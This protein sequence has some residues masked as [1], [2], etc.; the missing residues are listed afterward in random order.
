MW[1][2]LPFDILANIFS[3]LPPHSLACANAVCRHW[4]ACATAWPLQ[5][6]QH[7]PW[8]MALPARNCELGCLAHNPVCDSWV[9]LPLDFVPNPVRPVGSK[10]GLVLFR[11][12]SS[13]NFRLAIC[14]PFTQEYRQL[15]MLN[16]ERSSPAV[17]VVATNTG[18]SAPLSSYKSQSAPL[19]SYK[20]YV[21][22]GMSERPGSIA[23]YEPMLEMYDSD[24]DK[25]QILG[26]MPIEFAVRLTVW[27]PNDNVYS[28]GKLYWM[29]SARAYSIMC[30]D[31][32]T[33]TWKELKVPMADRL[34]FAALVQQTGKLT[35]VGGIG[36]GDACV[37]QL[38]EGNKWD[39]IQ[40]VPYVIKRKLLGEN[41]SWE[42]TNCVGSDKAI[43][44]YKDV[45]SGMAVWR[46]V[47][48]GR[49]EW[50]WIEG[51]SVRGK[52]KRLQNFPLKGLLLHP[53]L[54]HFVSIENK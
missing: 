54:A 4:H 18:Q 16:V 9:E 1:N 44:L 33:N 43:Y 13:R 53:N 12:Q 22:G 15:P 8:F 48:N 52:S 21:A 3:Y 17:G 11:V 36:G 23:T 49:W 27:T 25:W 46:E 37:W 31:I 30:F 39:L 40:K 10:E 7:P 50:F 42:H 6:R 41:A 20:I 14:N 28:E 34:E 26:P 19:S 35:L 38:S 51:Y 24:H 32:G 45:W 5:P 29:T 2:H 47:E